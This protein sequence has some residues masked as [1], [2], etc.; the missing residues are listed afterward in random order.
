MDCRCA[1]LVALVAAQLAVTPV[2]SQFKSTTIYDLPTLALCGLTDDSQL[3][4]QR[5]CDALITLY[6]STGEVLSG[7][8]TGQFY[9][10]Y[11]GVTC[12]KHSN[13]TAKL[14]LQSMGLVGTIPPKLGQLEEMWWL[15]LSR[16][17]FTGPI[18]VELGNLPV[19]E[20]IQ[21]DH[22][23]LTG[24]IP[25][26][27]FGMVLLDQT[28]NLHRL[29]T[30][31]LNWNQLSGPIPASIGYMGDTS[32]ISHLRP[33]AT[34]DVVRLGNNQL[35]GT[36]PPTICRNRQLK[37]L[38]L[39]HNLLTG[40]LPA[41]IGNLN[42]LSHFTVNNN[43]LG[44]ALPSSIGNMAMV[45]TFFAQKNKLTGALPS[46]IGGMTLLHKLRLDNNELNG[47]V[48]AEIGRL[49]SLWMVL[50][51]K[52]KLTGIHDDF[53]NHMLTHT[54]DFGENDFTCASIPKCAKDRCMAR[55]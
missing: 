11:P 54:C 12:A 45:R 19:I 7:W 43:A 53:C 31:S 2:R 21:L 18:P 14:N 42:I 26:K 13:H 8:A 17:Q 23:R 38:D 32:G 51:S 3:S 16:N 1:W 22:N 48:P 49:K 29:R 25:E 52:N 4:F 5:E 33:K 35:T 50:M 9:C 41:D 55:C 37:T 28:G 20:N 40:P 44:G 36:I 47:I 15:D 10:T 27:L 46:A 24:H 39:Q 34:M 30:L 6:R